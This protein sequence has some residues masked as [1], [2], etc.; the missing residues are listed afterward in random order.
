MKE[1]YVTF[2]RHDSA[3][4]MEVTAPLPTD[5]VVKLRSFSAIG[6]DN[7]GPLLV[8]SNGENVKA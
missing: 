4:A 2:R 1:A 5:L 3:P 6:E 8:K 7:A